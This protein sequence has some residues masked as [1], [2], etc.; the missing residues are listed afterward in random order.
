MRYD[1][2]IV[3]AGVAGCATAL[4]IKKVNKSLR[5]A[6][7]ERNKSIENPFK[8]GETLPPQT[9]KQFQN[10]NIWEAFLSCNFSSSYGTS[11][12][13][14]SN[15]LYT[16][17]YIFSPYGYG[18][19]LDRNR[20]DQFMMEQAKLKAVD[21]YFNTSCVSSELENSQWQL[22][23]ESDFKK[24]FVTASFVVDASG[25]KAAFSTLQGIKK[26]KSDKQVGIY[27]FYDVKQDN[28]VKVKEG[29]VVETNENGW[30]YSATLPNHKL[31]LGYMTDSDLANDLKIKSAANFDTLLQETKIT[32]ERTI[33]FKTKTTPFLVA[34][35][36]QYLSTSVGEGWLAVGDAASSYD[37]ISSLGIYKSLVMSQWASFAIIDSLKKVENGLKKYNHLIK[38]DFQLYEEKRL[39]YYQQEKRFSEAIFWKRRHYN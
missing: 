18:W 20:F 23:C 12:L 34:A 30:W 32:R 33:S 4:A 24:V 29:I 26:V 17:E 1:V 10:L 13:W 28:E 15:E 19:N 9:S 38:Q 2:V 37:P 36:T 7:I 5:V 27:R 14:G 21:F 16:N 3:G 25:K 35:Q 31:V 39:G 8:I 22:E 11:S 6:I